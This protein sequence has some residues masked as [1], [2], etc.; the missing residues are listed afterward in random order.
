M[1]SPIG[2][3]SSSPPGPAEVDGELR[4]EGKSGDPL[5]ALALL[6]PALR[7]HGKV[8]RAGDIVITGSLIGMH[9]FHGHRELKGSIDGCGEVAMR[10]IAAEEA[11]G[12]GASARTP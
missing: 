8:L 9:W 3:R 7:A 6:P 4:A 10:L 5:A 1:P 12:D 11:K 2:A